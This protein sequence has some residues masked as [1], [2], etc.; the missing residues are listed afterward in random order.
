MCLQTVMSS[1]EKKKYLEKLSNEIT[2]WKVVCKYLPG[3]YTTDCRKFPLHAGEVKFRQNTIY[4]EV[5]WSL[6][7][8]G[9][10]H[11][12]KTRAGARY[13][14]NYPSDRVI[15][16]IIK[17]EWINTIGTQGDFIVFVV[18]RAIFPEFLG[19]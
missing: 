16:C 3:R 6:S 15:K 19:T 1:K 11:F 9:G 14:A 10:G 18:K 5:D 12:W 17:K 13:W 7:Y 8:R 2:V 4:T